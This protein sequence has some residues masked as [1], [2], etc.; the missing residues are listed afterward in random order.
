MFIFYISLYTMTLVLFWLAVK[1]LRKFNCIID[2]LYVRCKAHVLAKY[3]AAF[4]LLKN[5]VL[6]IYFTYFVLRIYV[7]DFRVYTTSLKI[8]LVQS[9]FTFLTVNVIEDY[10]N[11]QSGKPKCVRAPLPGCTVFK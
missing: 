3:A 11:S 10:S 5:Q 7:R 8:E 1:L 6:H 4:A 2:V 9:K